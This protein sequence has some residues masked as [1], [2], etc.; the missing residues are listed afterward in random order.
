MRVLSVYHH[1]RLPACCRWARLTPPEE[2]PVR[3][4]LYRLAPLCALLF[5][6]SSASALATGGG[7][8]PP[9]DSETVYATLRDEIVAVHF[10]ASPP[11]AT[12]VNSDEDARKKLSSL[13]VLHAG[14]VLDIIASDLGTGQVLLYAGATGAGVEITGPSEIRFPDGLSSDEERNLY[15][16]SGKELYRIPSGGARPGDF[17]DPELI[18]GAAPCKLSDTRVVPFTQG[19]LVRGD[20][21]AACHTGDILR[22]PADSGGFGAAE[23]FIEGSSHK[24]SHSDGKSAQVVGVAFSPESELLVTTQKGV[25]RYDADGVR[26]ANFSNHRRFADISVGIQDLEHWA[27]LAD[28]DEDGA[29]RRIAFAADGSSGSETAVC[30]GVR[31]PSDVAIASAPAVPT[32]VG[33]MVSV[34][35][36]EQMEVT[37][38]E[39]VESGLTGVRFVELVD[40]RAHNV[41]QPLH[42][43][44]PPGSPLRD[45]LPNAIIPGY[46]RGLH[47]GAERIILLAIVDVT[48]GWGPT[49]EVHF[50]EELR[51]ISG[52]PPGSGLEPCAADLEQ[53]RQEWE[54]RTWF[55]PEPAKGDPGIVE[56]R[57]FDDE[58]VFTDVSVDCGSN[59]SRSWDFSLYATA[60]DIRTLPEIIAFK[61]NNLSEV[62]SEHGGLIHDPQ[63]GDLVSALGDAEGAFGDYEESC[64]T[65]DRDDALAALGTFVGIATGNPGAF[66]NASRN[67]QGEVLARA[68]SLEY[69]IPKFTCAPPSDPLAIVTDHLPKAF[70]YKPYVVQLEASGGTPEYSWS[71]VDGHLPYGLSLSTD[72][73]ISGKP[74]Q[75]G[76][77]HILVKV[78]DADGAKAYRHFKLRVK[79]ICYWGHEH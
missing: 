42:D 4:R 70:K 44:L 7:A 51:G 31:H 67:I 43:F 20:L 32:P 54:P 23:V 22:Y 40:D 41:D 16:F 60:R 73:V 25:L 21:L 2:I 29:I 75:K 45:E 57:L 76:E 18:D 68:R 37:Y 66:E 39:V 33:T 65:A 15:L 35:P 78:R 72:G 5:I 64:E 74:K 53:E 24:K 36:T 38:D 62:L 6:S 12:V 10:D 27:F 19:G 55:A 34:V 71:I 79:Y 52:G 13:V 26:L 9:T 14:D 3:T 50:E 77:F 61:F 28:Q 11:R 56:E 30:K 1:R 17:G 47:R 48:A 58:V 8:A 49:A 46:M 59:V 69:F 63:R